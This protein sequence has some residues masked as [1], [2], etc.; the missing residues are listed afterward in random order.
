MS[1]GDHCAPSTRS[2]TVGQLREC[3]L[4]A[5]LLGE[6]V[7]CTSYVCFHPHYVRGREQSILK[8]TRRATLAKCVLSSLVVWHSLETWEVMPPSQSSSGLAHYCLGFSVPTRQFQCV[9]SVESHQTGSQTQQMTQRKW[10]G[11]E[12][13]FE[14]LACFSGVPST[15]G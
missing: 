2:T 8:I 5:F 13:M 3:T 9:A 15:C 10:A 7:P 11:V 6:R 1:A 4:A 14:K 12:W